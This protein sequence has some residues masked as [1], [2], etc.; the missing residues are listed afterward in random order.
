MTDPDYPGYP[1]EKFY[2]RATGRCGWVGSWSWW[3]LVAYCL[4]RFVEAVFPCVKPFLLN[5]SG[6]SVM[7]IVE[8]ISSLLTSAGAT[9]F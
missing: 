5:M 1:T 7:N 8:L 3:L 9:A 2:R 6:V 4:F